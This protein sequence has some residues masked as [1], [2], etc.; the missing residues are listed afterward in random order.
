MRK[1]IM[2]KYILPLIGVAALSCVSQVVSAAC[3]DVTRSVLEAAVLAAKTAGT[4]TG[5]YGLPMWV[6]MVDETGK[7]CHVAT[8]GVSGATAG[9]NEWLGSRVISAQ[10]ANT[11]NAFSLDGY[12]I[13]TANLYSAV[14]PGGS[15]YG[16]QFSN[17]VAPAM[18]YA[19]APAAYGTVTDPLRGKRVGGVNV[20]GGGL[21]LY[22][23]GKKVG[24][25][26][27]SGDTSCRDHAF[28][29]QVRTALNAHP[30]G[31]GITTS[32]MDASGT[33]QPPLTSGLKG[34]EMILNA[35][36]TTTPYWDA[37]SQ[38]TCPNSLPAAANPANGT[39]LN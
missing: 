11:A 25:I 17:P 8:S 4:A 33:P 13:S 12:A 34:D 27:V 37:W 28:A 38:P 7:V 32:N 14:Q 3:T 21:A 20:F 36:T 23:G 35:A 39:I 31:S 30:T 29:W 26:G 10:K 15:L 24:A 5:G 19:G 1:K 9:N 16:L 18:A 2:K 22:I 6:T